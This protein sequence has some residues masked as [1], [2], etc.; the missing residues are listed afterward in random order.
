[1]DGNHKNREGG[2]GGEKRLRIFVLSLSSTNK[3]FSDALKQSCGLL[4]QIYPGMLRVYH[5]SRER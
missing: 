3:Q 4:D 5:F 1:M 2:W